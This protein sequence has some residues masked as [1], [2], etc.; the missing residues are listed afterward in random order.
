MIY[1]RLVFNKAYHLYMYI[2][3]ILGILNI[4]NY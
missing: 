2:S 1:T 3:Y 4:Y